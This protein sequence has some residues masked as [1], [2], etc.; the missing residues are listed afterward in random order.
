MRLPRLVILQLGL[1]RDRHQLD[2]LANFDH[3]VAPVGELVLAA[4]RRAD[5]DLAVEAGVMPLP[6]LVLYLLRT[7]KEGLACNNNSL[8]SFGHSVPDF[9][10]EVKGPFHLTNNLGSRIILAPLV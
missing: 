3:A 8:F 10:K 2:L 4:E 9:Q 1:V 6:S 7:S 5:A